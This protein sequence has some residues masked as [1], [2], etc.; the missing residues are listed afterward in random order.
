MVERKR[1]GERETVVLGTE[2]VI[3]VLANAILEVLD[4]V[5]VFMPAYVLLFGLL[6]GIDRHFHSVIKKTIRFSIVEN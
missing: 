1:I 2:N 6:F 3:L 4:V 5:A